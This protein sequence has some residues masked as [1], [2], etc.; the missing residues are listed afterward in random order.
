MFKEIK[1]NKKLYMLIVEQIEN[2][3]KDGSLKP[4]DKLPSERELA[5]QFGLSRSS[6]REAITALE[7]FGLVN[8]QPGLGTFISDEINNGDLSKSYLELEDNISPTDITEAR[9]IIEPTLARLAAQRA[10]LEDL[11]D[12]KEIIEESESY[13]ID[14]LEKFE[15]CDEQIHLLIAKAAYNEILYKFTESI[16]AFRDSKL[17]GSMKWKS[18]K[19][20]GRISKY[21]QEHREIYEALLNRNS[22]KAEALIRTHLSEIKKDIFDESN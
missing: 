4:G 20:E 13:D 22:E 15:R 17:W 7:I 3:I 19:K 2:L 9:L 8:I 16:N 1:K 18:I 12:L 14:D 5:T 10:T 6:V 21:K 11:N